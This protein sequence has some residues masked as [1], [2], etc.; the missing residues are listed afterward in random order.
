MK[1]YVNSVWKTCQLSLAIVAV[2]ALMNYSRILAVVPWSRRSIMRGKRQ[3]K[4]SNEPIKRKKCSNVR[5][6]NDLI[7]DAVIRLYTMQFV[8]VNKNMWMWWVQGVA[9]IHINQ[10]K[11]ALDYAVAMLVASWALSVSLAEL[12]IKWRGIEVCL[13]NEDVRFFWWG[14]FVKV[15]NWY[16]TDVGVI[17]TF[18][19]VFV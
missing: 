3:G 17:S 9:A 13:F 12:G 18:G 5:Q 11:V 16:H 7:S 15:V 2:D 8:T 6:I 10:V 1:S 19:Q 14:R 4:T